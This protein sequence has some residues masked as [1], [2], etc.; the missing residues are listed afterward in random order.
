MQV[1]SDNLMACASCHFHAGADNRVKNQL[2]PDGRQRLGSDRGRP[3]AAAP[4]TR[5]RGGLPVP[6]PLRSDRSRVERGVRHRRRRRIAGRLQHTVRP[7]P[8]TA[9]K[10]HPGAD[11]RI[12]GQRRRNSSGDGTKR[13]DRDQ[14]GVELPQLLGRPCELR[15]QRRVA[16]RTARQEGVHL[17]GR[18]VGRRQRNASRARSS[19]VCPHSV[20]ERCVAG[21]R[22]RAERLRDVGR[23]AGVLGP[24]PQ[25]AL[26]AAARQSERVRHR[27]RARHVPQPV[28]YRPDDQAATKR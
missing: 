3:T 12:R 2:N 21:G 4:T 24:R 19:G 1:S 8:R 9:R 28:W 17:G 11:R 20:R 18:L 14:R 16:V 26:D 7:E 6:P 10:E 23:E 15:V 27:Q 22:P 13:A 5:S 25:A